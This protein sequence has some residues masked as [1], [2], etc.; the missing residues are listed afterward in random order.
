MH[1]QPQTNPSDARVS[2]LGLVSESEV[3]GEVAMQWVS[4]D[5]DIANLLLS[6]SLTDRR[7]VLRP[8]LAP[9]VYVFV[10]V[11]TTTSFTTQGQGVFS[12]AGQLVTGAES[13]VSAKATVRLVVN[14]RP[15]NGF[16]TI[17]PASGVALA[18]EFS[19]TTGG[20]VDDVEVRV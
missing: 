16:V 14:G 19:M 5:T 3:G 7:L 6:P 13:V 17:A 18:T 4:P 20:W 11:A 15:Q 1:A 10:L 9:G 2:L 8:D 12:K